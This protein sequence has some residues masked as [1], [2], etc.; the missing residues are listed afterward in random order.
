MQ[1]KEEKNPQKK[2]ANKLI[3]SVLLKYKSE[4]DKSKL[5]FRIYVNAQGTVLREYWYHGE[6]APRPTLASPHFKFIVKLVFDQHISEIP[7]FRIIQI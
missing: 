2:T 6:M 3:L 4:N 7:W 5:P 1:K